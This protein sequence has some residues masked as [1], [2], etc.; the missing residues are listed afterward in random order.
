MLRYK[1]ILVAID[2]S[3]TSLHALKESFK[4]VQKGGC[5]ITVVSVV[6]PYTGDLDLVSVGDIMG[7][8]KKPY[9]DAL[10]QADELAKTEGVSI[11]TIC[12]E[13]EIYE[14]VVDLAKSENYDLIVVGR[15]GLRRLERILVGS[16]TARII[17]HT[18]KDV[19]VIPGD[20]VIG[21]ENVL[22]ATDGS[23][24]SQGATERAISFTKSYHRELK[25]VSVVD[26]PT[27]FYGEAPEV[28]ETLIQQAKGFVDEVK[29]KAE[30]DGIKVVTFVRE[31]EAYK[32]ITEL[33][34]NEKVD[35]IFMGSHGRT[36]LKRVLMGSVTEEVIGHTPCPVVVVK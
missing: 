19:L 23:K 26:V 4:F 11:K 14:R 10:S 34:K 7:S 5:E 29:E 16:V 18:Q 2:G 20:T 33:A 6:P 36:G 9:Q 1:K 30:A 22:L 12:E 13:G 32:V 35:V 17:G 15:R 25:V 21:W 31:G 3:E 28:A 24:C 8:M 27:E